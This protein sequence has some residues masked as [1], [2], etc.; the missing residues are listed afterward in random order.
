MVYNLYKQGIL[1]KRPVLVISH[2]MH[3]EL[4]IM[5]IYKEDL[6]IMVNLK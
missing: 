4:L 6:E 5:Y 2:V 3:Q 1:H